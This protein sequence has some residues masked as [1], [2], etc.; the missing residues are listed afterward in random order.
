[1]ATKSRKGRNPGR[2]KPV[3]ADTAEEPKPARSTP[4]QRRRG[5]RRTQGND[6]PRITPNARAVLAA[7]KA[8]QIDGRPRPFPTSHELQSYLR[9][10]PDQSEQQAGEMFNQTRLEHLGGA[11]RVKGFPAGVPLWLLREG[12]LSP[13][14][15]G[16]TSNDVQRALWRLV[17]GFPSWEYEVAAALSELRSDGLIVDVRI[18]ITYDFEYRRPDGAIVTVMSRCLE[19]ESDGARVSPESAD[20]FRRRG[21]EVVPPEQPHTLI[22]VVVRHHSSVIDVGAFI[23]NETLPPMDGKSIFHVTCVPMDRNAFAGV[24]LAGD[25]RR[26]GLDELDTEQARRAEL[27]RRIEMTLTG[28]THLSRDTIY[29]QCKPARRADV[30]AALKELEIEGTYRPP[31][32]SRRA[33]T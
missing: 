3:R 33:R 14:P 5:R 31:Q 12:E 19:T 13:R 27:K 16:R 10:N 18:P 20:P 23:E 21:L 17:D 15:T 26:L 7:I 28:D 32:G 22:A 6:K 29:D 4:V 8:L 9:R 24:R 30:Y 11:Q 25:W 1:M 2:L